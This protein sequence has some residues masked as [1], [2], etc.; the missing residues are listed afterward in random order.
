[1]GT[2]AIAKPV[3]VLMFLDCWLTPRRNSLLAGRLF[4]CVSH[5]LVCVRLA[6][7]KIMFG[8]VP[9]SF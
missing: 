5:I 2:C 9:V 6:T 7:A 8:L 4:H 1:M 3:C